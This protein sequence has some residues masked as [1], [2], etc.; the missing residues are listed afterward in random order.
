MRTL[1]I[2]LLAAVVPAAAQTQVNKI[3]PVKTGQTLRLQFDYPAVKITSWD[4]NEIA[5]TG[6]VSINGGESDDA[7]ELIVDNSGNV[8]SVRSEIRNMK[9]LPHRVT[10]TIGGQKIRFRDK[11][12]W[13]KYQDEHGVKA[14]NVNMGVDM[15]IEL[16]IK[17]PRNMDTRIDAVYGMVE[18]R[19]FQ[20]PLQVEATYGGVDVALTEQNVGELT[21]ETHYGTIFSNLNFKPDA[22]NSKEED[23]HLYVSA[24]LGNGPRVRVG[25]QYGNVYLRKSQK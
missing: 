6:E 22:N 17:V 15:D 24:K 11:T 5:I 3:V 13:R 1:L 18:V 20:G 14:T 12:E 23:F 7:F 9:S 4:K 21:A 10:A 8:I 25:S 2:L 19:D 16:E